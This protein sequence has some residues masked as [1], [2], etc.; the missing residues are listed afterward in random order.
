MK[1]MKGTDMKSH[2]F[3]LLFL[4]LV[5]AGSAIADDRLYFYPECSPGQQCMDLAYGDG[6]TD[7]VLAAPV[8]IL[9]KADI[10]AANIQMDASIPKALNIELGEEASKKF[11]KITGANIGKKLM[12]VFDNI[13][14]TAPM[15]NAPITSRSITIRRGPGNQNP[16]W[17]RAPWLQDIIRESSKAGGRSV[18]IYAIV[19]LAVSVSAFAF[20]LIP[21]M[22]RARPS[23]VE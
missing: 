7:S 16:F 5:L 19:A 15:V 17:E 2:I 1:G 14:L 8:L 4:I 13:I 6:K 23:E 9:G 12:V 21:R 22:K 18:M 11:E 3:A 20:I 10:A